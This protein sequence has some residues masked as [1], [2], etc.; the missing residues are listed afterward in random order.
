VMRVQLAVAR[1]FSATFDIFQ[2][3][4]YSSS[5]KALY[6]KIPESPTIRDIMSPTSMAGAQILV[7]KKHKDEKK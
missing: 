3:L 4:N 7:N 5:R 2:F 1:C 6:I